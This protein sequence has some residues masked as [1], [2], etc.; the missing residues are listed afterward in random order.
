MCQY[1]AGILADCA[2]DQGKRIRELEATLA[3]I[4]EPIQNV[5]N[6]VEQVYKSVGG[7]APGT[8]NWLLQLME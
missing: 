4:R 6:I 8:S 2:V 5:E 3:R 7:R 1:S